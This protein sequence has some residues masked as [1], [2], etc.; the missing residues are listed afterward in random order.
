MPFIGSTS[1]PSDDRVVKASL[2]CDAS[3]SIGDWV[4]YASGIL[5]KATADD[6]YNSDVVG[7]VEE[8]PSSILA[9]VLVTGI[10][11]EIFIGLDISKQYFLSVTTPGGMYIPP[12]STSSGSVILCLGRPIT[13]TQFIVRVAQRMYRS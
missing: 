7:L 2:T 11:K 13:S 4:R 8:K 12:V 5:V 1:L 10:S 3:V 9:N 6:R